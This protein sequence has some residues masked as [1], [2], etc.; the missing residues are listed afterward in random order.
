MARNAKGHALV[1]FTYLFHA[2]ELREHP[3]RVASALA[4]TIAE[5]RAVC[6]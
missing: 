1:H 3:Y 2:V 5:F 6:S 4:S